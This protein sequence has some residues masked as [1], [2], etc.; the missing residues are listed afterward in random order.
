MAPVRT[1]LTAVLVVALTSYASDCAPV[2]SLE[3]A[4]ECCKSMCPLHSHQQSM[5]CCKEASST[6]APFV[7]PASIHSAALEWT[8]FAVAAGFDVVPALSGPV[9]IL[10]VAQSH[11]PPAAQTTAA[12]PLRI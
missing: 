6:H 12:L 3:Q 10:V 4:M 1:L 11:A 8:V 5:D 2:A 9:N 7:Q